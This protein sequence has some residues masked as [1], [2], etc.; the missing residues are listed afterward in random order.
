MAGVI[1]YGVDGGSVNTYSVA[2]P[3]PPIASLSAG[4]SI[5]VNI[6]NRNTAASTLSVFIGS[7]FSTPAPITLTNGSPVAPGALATNQ[8][9]L[10]TYDGNNWQI[11]EG[12]VSGLV[13]VEQ[14]GAKG[15]G[16]DDT[17]ALQQADMA[18]AL[19]FTSG[20]TYQINGSPEFKSQA[21][22][23]PGS[24]ISIASGQ[25]VTFDQAP[26]AGAYK[27]FQGAGAVVIKGTGLA[28][29]FGALGNNTNNDGPA[30]NAALNACSSVQLLARTYYIATTTIALPAPAVPKNL[31][32]AGMDLTFITFKQQAQ[33]CISFYG[34]DGT[35]GNPSNSSF[36]IRGFTIINVN[37]QNSPTEEPLPPSTAPTGGA[38]ININ[39][40][41]YGKVADIKIWY[42]W[43]G[44]QMTT[45]LNPVVTRIVLLHGYHYSIMLQDALVSGQWVGG[46]IG[47]EFSDIFGY[48]V[49][50]PTNGTQQ[51]S[52]GLY[53]VINGDYTPT[54]LTDHYRSFHEG[55]VFK[56][57]NFAGYINGLLIS[58]NSSAS[59]CAGQ[60][61]WRVGS[62][63]Y[64]RFLSC[65]FDTCSNGNKIN[66]VYDS[67]FS[68][69]SQIVG[70]PTLS[71]RTASV[72]DTG[73]RY[74][75]RAGSNSTD[76]NLFLIGTMGFS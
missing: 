33:D 1:P 48:G 6:Q 26:S 52:F 19:T 44:I 39:W 73:F 22:F 54:S 7:S 76:A 23:S 29:W 42:C 60:L 45:L 10:M 38:A 36:E 63:G 47:G 18:G 32:G 43:G 68:G 65:F 70:L 46:V 59:N 40:C 21:V 37:G 55:I 31:I 71:D 72:V 57:C 12:L 2:S 53:M 50:S 5:L 8:I 51:C 28:E 20:K 58:G 61:V 41:S 35:S 11:A 9:L 62:S 27:I 17:L 16:G 75:I 13:S 34:I 69:F 14:F 30:I 49:V 4:V 67:I 56:N 66:Y 24:M 64:M 74:S 25:T 3:N 15:D